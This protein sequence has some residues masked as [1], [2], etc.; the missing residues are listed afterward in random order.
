MALGRPRG[1][2]I[3]IVSRYDEARE[4]THYHIL[5]AEAVC[6]FC[7]DNTVTVAVKYGGI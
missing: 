5:P 7:F 6:C 4:T 3:A 1:A 2:K